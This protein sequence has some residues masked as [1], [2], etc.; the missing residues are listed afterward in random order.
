MVFSDS[1]SCLPPLSYFQ[2][3]QRRE[4]KDSEAKLRGSL[5]A[6]LGSHLPHLAAI[7]LTGGPGMAV[8]AFQLIVGGSEKACSLTP[9]R[10][11]QI[12]PPSHAC[13]GS[14][15][16]KIGTVHCSSIYN[17]QDMEAT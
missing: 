15:Y 7:L 12:N 1:C 13:F 3:A 11:T 5:L 10:N 4:E 17:S 16:T 6:W 2:G 9:K 14:T 8:Q